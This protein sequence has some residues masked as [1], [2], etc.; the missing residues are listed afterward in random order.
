[1]SPEASDLSKSAK[2]RKYAFGAVLGVILLYF[3]GE[4]FLDNVLQGPVRAAR[5]ETTKLKR[6]IA[7]KEKSV[8]QAKQLRQILDRLE[9]QSLPSD[10]QVARSLYQQWLFELVEDIELENPSVNS[11]EPVSR[12]GIYQTLSFSVRGRGTLEKLTRFLFAF[13]RTD[14]L[15][16]I[17]SVNIVPL[18]ND[19]RLDLSM[20]IDAMVL[21]NATPEQGKDAS[22]ETI[23]EEFRRRAWRSSTRLA[24][25]ELVAYDPII[26]RDLFGIG[27]PPD[28]TDHAFLTSINI[29]DG[30]PTVWI[31]LRASD[32]VLKLAQGDPFT[33]GSVVGTVLEVRAPDVVI[34]SDGERWL[35][36]L[37]DKLTEAF[38]LPPEL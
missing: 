2:Y 34:E 9:S 5:L 28:P 36:S 19:D 20:A 26:Q 11:S 13:Y 12:K 29:V 18:S 24:S 17:R 8:Q 10:A 1:M 35:L 16:Q 15:H 14:L 4:W 21:P 23:F 38:A 25:Y 27:G 6:E 3:A 30:V 7:R 31:T 32:E 37:G 33:I 22:Q